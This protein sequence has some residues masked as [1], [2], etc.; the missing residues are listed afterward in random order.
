MINNSVICTTYFSR[1]QHPNDPN[2]SAVIGRDSDGR[3]LQNDIK[4]IEPWYNSINNLNLN[5]IVF[6]D[7]LT[8]EFID[9]YQTSQIRFIK[10]E[11][12]D[13]SNNDWRFFVYR[14]FLNNNK[15]ESVFLTD[16]SDVIIVK[17][18]HDIVNQYKTVDLF[19]CKD[20]IKLV[21]FPYLSLHNQVRWDGR[22]Y[23]TKNNSNFDL[24]NMGVIGG[25]YD[26]II[27]FLD[28]KDQP[29]LKYKDITIISEEKDRHF[30]LKKKDKLQKGKNIL[31]KYG[32][33]SSDK[34]LEELINLKGEAVPYKK[35]KIHKL[36]EKI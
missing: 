27:D 19:V 25:S 3:V 34:L 33:P 35:V 14:D 30:R 36:K 4:Y 18:P 11:S 1:K 22:I 2:D 16:G 12:S 24:I 31:Q 8:D 7:N 29:G 13:Y 20:S 10:V 15:Y 28:K 32:I 23:F 9:R 21:D 17:E 5:G 6:Y 26:N